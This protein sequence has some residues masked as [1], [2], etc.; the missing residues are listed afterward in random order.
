MAENE[1]RRKRGKAHVVTFVENRRVETF[2]IYSPLTDYFYCVSSK[3]RKTVTV[4]ICF[5][6]KC[7]NHI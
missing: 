4:A 1:F 5:T 2:L 6:K 7:K 3:L